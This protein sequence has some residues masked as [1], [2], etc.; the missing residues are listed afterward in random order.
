MEGMTSLL[1]I[2]ALAIAAMATAAM[3][4]VMAADTPAVPPARQSI[5]LGGGCFWCVESAFEAVPGVLEAVSGYAAGTVDDPTYEQVCDGGTGQ[6]EV[7][8]V[9]YDPAVVPLDT[10]LDLFFHVH[11][12]TTKNR[13]GADRGTQYRSIILVTDTVQRTAALA[14]MGRAQG[15][16]RDPIVTEVVDLAPS[17]PG[18]F[19]RAEEY[20]QD[21]FRLNPNQGYCLATIPPK[22]EKVRKFLEK[23]PADAK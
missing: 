10:L 9:V 16:L 1:A 17:G 14:A 7:V 23:K 8:R 3:V 19:H 6:A 18:R 4:P 20:H 21:Y 22:L 13:Q 12:P 11:D 15:R 2:A 5:V